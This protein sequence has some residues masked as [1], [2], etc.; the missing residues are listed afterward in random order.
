MLEK[1]E[2][3]NLWEDYSN[4]SMKSE[5]E[6][7]GDTIPG[8]KPK[9]INGRS[10]AGFGGVGLKPGHLMS[11]LIPTLSVNLGKL[12]LLYS[13]HLFLEWLWGFS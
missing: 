2:V 12:F 3:H 11:N 6:E 4:K 1:S 13:L 10:S 7:T 9:E 5:W 8:Q